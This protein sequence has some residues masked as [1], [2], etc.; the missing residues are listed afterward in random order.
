MGSPKR[1]SCAG[2]CHDSVK[3]TIETLV[4]QSVISLPQ[5]EEVKIQRERRL[6]EGGV[7]SL[8][9]LEEVKIEELGLLPFE[10]EAR[11]EGRHGGGDVIYALLNEDQAYFLLT[12][13]RFF[14]KSEGFRLKR[15][16]FN[17]PSAG[18]LLYNYF[19]G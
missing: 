16:P 10:K 13:S 7:I 9:P 2:F 19:A 14:Q 18:F 12:L 5:I 3:R 17:P 4:E 8:P 6:A 1:P 15:E 11:P